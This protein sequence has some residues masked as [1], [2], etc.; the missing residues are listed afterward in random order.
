VS[1]PRPISVKRA[2]N[3]PPVAFALYAAIVFGICWLSYTG[4][5]Q[6]GYNWQWYQ[7]PKY[8]YT[9]TDDGFQVGE[10]ITGVWATIKLSLVSFALATVL[11][12][13]V[14]LLRLSGL[15]VG[16]GLAVGYLEFIRNLPLLVLL[17]LI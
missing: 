8:F 11:G 15:I 6:M 9:L 17:Y 12:L 13:C 7:I 2:L 10:I 4:A 3:A 16:V 14:A 1:A 5:Q